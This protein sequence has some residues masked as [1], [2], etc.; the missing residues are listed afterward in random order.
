MLQLNIPDSLC[1]FFCLVLNSIILQEICIQL[2]DGDALDLLAKEISIVY[3]LQA[4]AE[5]VL[6]LCPLI[7]L[8]RFAHLTAIVRVADPQKTSILV[9]RIPRLYPVVACSCG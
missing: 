6:S 8:R 4:F 5:K 7:S 2:V 9:P 3:G 1:T